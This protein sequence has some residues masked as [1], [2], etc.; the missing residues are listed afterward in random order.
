MQIL[1]YE[2]FIMRNFFIIKPEKFFYE[3][4]FANKAKE[5][6]ENFMIKIF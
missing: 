5:N 4:F 6:I 3:K 1:H 2:E